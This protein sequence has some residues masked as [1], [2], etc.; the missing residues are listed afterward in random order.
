[1][2]INATW[3]GEPI[4]SGCVYLNHAWRVDSVGNFYCDG[5]GKNFYSLSPE[6]QKYERGRLAEKRAR[7]RAYEKKYGTYG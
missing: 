1:M 2:K 3:D 4:T 5:C 7:I 6:R